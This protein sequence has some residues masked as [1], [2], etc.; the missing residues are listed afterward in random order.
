MSSRNAAGFA[1]AAL[2]IAGCHH[3]CPPG[4]SAEGIDVPCCRAG[5]EGRP[6]KIDTGTAPWKVTPPSGSAAQPVVALSNVAWTAVAPA[7]WVGSPDPNAVAF[8]EHV[9][10]LGFKIAKCDNPT[11]ATITGSFAADNKAT[12]YLDGNA[13][14]VATSQGTPDYGFLPGSVTPFTVS[15]PGTSGGAHTLK[16]VVNN[17]GGPSG[18]VLRGAISNG[19]ATEA[20]R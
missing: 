15:V 4:P 8:G 5:G 16:V 20:G 19:C 1:A 9:Y 18:L 6:V 12:V 3:S 14:P 10:E 2:L 17:S 11:S 13:T 7:A